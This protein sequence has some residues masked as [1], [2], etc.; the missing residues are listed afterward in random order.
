MFKILLAHIRCLF[1]D[2]IKANDHFAECL[3]EPDDL[4][5]RPLTACAHGS[6]GEVQLVLRNSYDAWLEVPG[7]FELIKMLTGR[8]GQNLE[9]FQAMFEEENATASK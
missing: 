1:N 4:L 6:V 7:S 8:Y 5:A 2:V 9:D 3:L